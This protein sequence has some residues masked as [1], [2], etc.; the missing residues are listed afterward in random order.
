MESEIKLPLSSRFAAIVSLFKCCFIYL[1]KKNHQVSGQSL[2]QNLFGGGLTSGVGI[3][4][5]EIMVAKVFESCHF[6]IIS[7]ILSYSS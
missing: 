5:L 7:N 4:H 6:K 2:N 1:F 3:V